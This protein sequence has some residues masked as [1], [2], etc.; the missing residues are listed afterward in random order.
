MIT[1]K[2]NDT[3]SPEAI[4]SGLKHIERVKGLIL[5]LQLF[6]VLLDEGLLDVVRYELIA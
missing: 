6:L 3:I 5:F 4:T 1:S 2:A